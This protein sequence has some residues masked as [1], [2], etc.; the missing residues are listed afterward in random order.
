MIS[1]VSTKQVL[2]VFFFNEL[3][4]SIIFVLL[5]LL[6]KWNNFGQVQ[7]FITSPIITDTQTN[8]E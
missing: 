2:L 7:G 4:L 1:M 5:L 6:I 8:T 3:L